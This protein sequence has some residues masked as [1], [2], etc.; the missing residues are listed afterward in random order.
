M[1]L[2]NDSAFNLKNDKVSIKYFEEVN[3]LGDLHC[4][5]VLNHSAG[6]FLR[7]SGEYLE[8]VI[9]KESEFGSL[10]VEFIGYL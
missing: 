2:L 10:K 3:T 6:Y 1:D 4:Y 9:Y 8:H 7:S 5:F